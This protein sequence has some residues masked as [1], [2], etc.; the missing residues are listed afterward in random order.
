MCSVDPRDI[1]ATTHATTHVTTHATTHA[2]RPRDDPRDEATRRP[3]RRPR[4]FSCGRVN[5]TMVSRHLKRAAHKSKH[6]ARSRSRSRRAS[7]KSPARKHA[8]RVGSKAGRSR[9]RSRAGRSKA[10]WS[11]SRGGRRLRGGGL[12]T[13]VGVSAAAITVAAGGAWI[14]SKYFT[15]A[16]LQKAIK[17]LTDN[18]NL[19]G[20][21]TLQILLL[22]TALEKINLFGR[23]K[24]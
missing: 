21:N 2:T 6:A 8:H 17:L 20:Q 4:F 24:Q 23:D 10:G 22:K 11:R 3:T 5:N 15:K 13:Q 19:S 14:G 9:S 18:D 7:R 1:H 16:G 12:K